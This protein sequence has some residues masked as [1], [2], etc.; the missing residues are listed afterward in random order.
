MKL[1]IKRF[2]LVFHF[3]FIFILK[4]VY[5][6]RYIS[7]RHFLKGNLNGI[8][9]GVIGMWRQKILRFNSYIPWPAHY[10]IKISNVKRVHF[11]SDDLNI[12]QSQNVYFQ[13]IDADIYIG[14]GV[15]IA[16]NVGIITTNHDLNDLDKHVVG[17]D[18]NIG[19]GVWIGMNSVILPGVSIGNNSIIGAGSVVT[20]SIPENCVAVGNPCKVIRVL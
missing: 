5:D 15:Y 11:H 18:V 6:E 13:N 17:K 2:F 8:K 12:F 16:P 1:Y 10:S 7:G 3:F 19:S 4:L 20:K 14:K 9:W